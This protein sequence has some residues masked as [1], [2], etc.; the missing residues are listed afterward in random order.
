MTKIG[1][2]IMEIDDVR[3]RAARSKKHLLGKNEVAPMDLTLLLLR[4]S[5]GL[6]MNK[7]GSWTG[8]N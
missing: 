8:I 1:I 5:R 6:M 3:E 4:R 7:I 2:C